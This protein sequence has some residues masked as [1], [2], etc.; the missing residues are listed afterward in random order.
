M[1]INHNKTKKQKRQQRVRAKVRGTN[2]RPRLNVFRSNIN[3]YLQVID[4]AAGKTLLSVSTLGLEKKAGTKTEQ[5]KQVA[6]L[7]AEKLKKSKI[8][9]LVFDRGSYKYHGRVKAIAETM[10]EQGVQV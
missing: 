10:R 1:Y 9:K 4:D 6:Q 3:I 2:E 8:K 5:A 7:L